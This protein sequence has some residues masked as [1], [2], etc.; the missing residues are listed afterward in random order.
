MRH[1]AADLRGTRRHVPALPNEDGALAP[2]THVRGAHDTRID[3]RPPEFEVQVEDHA[4]AELRPPS[5]EG[6]PDQ[7]ER[8]VECLRIA[9]EG[10]E[11]RDL[12]RCAALVRHALEYR[13]HLF[14]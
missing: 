13:A 10:H 1:V 7:G 12:V 3:R 11:A 5:S 14:S 9:L 4:L 2:T 6:F 8:S